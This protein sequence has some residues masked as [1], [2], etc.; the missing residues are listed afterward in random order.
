MQDAPGP[1][2]ATIGMQRVL[3]LRKPVAGMI[4]ALLVADLRTVQAALVI[5]LR[6]VACQ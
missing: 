4:L 6:L 5:V 3:V 2:V 1:G